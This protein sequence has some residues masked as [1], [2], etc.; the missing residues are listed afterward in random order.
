M[1]NH[2]DDNVRFRNCRENPGGDPGFVA[3]IVDGKLCLFAV[4]TDST[5]N[6]IFHV[7]HLLFR[8]RSSR[9]VEAGTDL[10]WNREFFREF[11]GARL[12]HFGTRAGH[13][14]QLVVGN[15]IDFFCLTDQVRVAGKYAVHISENLA[16]I[17]IQC[18]SQ[19][20][21]S[22]IRAPATKNRCFSLVRLPLK[23]GN[24]DDVI[25]VQEIMDL[26]WTNVRD[27]RFC[28]HAISQ[29]ACFRAG[30]G[31]SAAAERVDCHRD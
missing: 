18:A 6:H 12:H 29:D 1:H 28:M 7:G 31:N 26:S 8:Q 19:R 14:Q 23:S 24:D 20:D 27:F 13:F 30:H 16:G 17:G 3:N 22:Q 4:D 5:H 11:D 10:K 21:C 25:L 15:F 9:V 2:I